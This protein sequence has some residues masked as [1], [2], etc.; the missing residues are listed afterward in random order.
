MSL[1]LW[2]FVLEEVS[3]STPSPPAISGFPER[4][5]GSHKTCHKSTKLQNLGSE[6]PGQRFPLI[7]LVKVSHEASK[8]FQ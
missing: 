1:S 6:I 8:W 3:Q 2:P 7:L 4:E 5:K